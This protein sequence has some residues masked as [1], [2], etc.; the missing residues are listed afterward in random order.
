MCQVC[1]SSMGLRYQALALD[2]GCGKHWWHHWPWNVKRRR[3]N[4]VKIKR[5]N[6]TALQFPVEC[7]LWCGWGIAGM[8]QKK[9][10][11]V[12][13]LKISVRASCLE[14]EPIH[15]HSDPLGI[16]VKNLWVRTVLVLSE[17]FYSRTPRKPGTLNFS[18]C[19]FA[20]SLSF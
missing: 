7:G 12:R 20:T 14:W 8:Q 2:C 4:P 16:N 13:H 18:D 11:S 17:L 19:L 10:I 1:D 5:Q 6:P 3:W 9:I 15:F